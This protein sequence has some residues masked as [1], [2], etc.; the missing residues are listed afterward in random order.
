M[1]RVV[2]LM[3]LPSLTGDVVREQFY[4]YIELPFVPFVGLTVTDNGTV[5]PV[6]E[7]RYV[8]EHDVFWCYVESE[9]LRGRS[10]EELSDD[11]VD[12]GGW[13]RFCRDSRPWFWKS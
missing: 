6:K 1:T 8:K 12:S 10:I 7:I 3:S 11:L 5:G 13:Q 9:D 2:F 4:R